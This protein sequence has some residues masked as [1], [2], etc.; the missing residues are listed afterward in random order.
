MAGCANPPTVQYINILFCFILFWLHVRWE[1]K[2]MLEWNEILIYKQ[3][4]WFRFIHST[5]R[6]RN[7]YR[8]YRIIVI[9][10]IV[11]A[12]IAIVTIYRRRHRSQQYAIR[13]TAQ[14][15]Q[16]RLRRQ[17]RWRLILIDSFPNLCSLKI[18]KPISKQK[19]KINQS[20]K[21]NQ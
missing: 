20:I 1:K 12:I 2:D 15:L 6:S 19:K 9:I 11:I 14:Y 13:S 10:V 18:L 4:N 5:S 17:Q 8:H 3:T 7:L 21:S 16:Q